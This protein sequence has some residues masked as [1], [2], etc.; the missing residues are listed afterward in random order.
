[1]YGCHYILGLFVWAIQSLNLFSGE[2]GY[3]HFFST[4]LF[5]PLS[6]VRPFWPSF[7]HQL[8]FTTGAW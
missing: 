7:P 2:E 6:S 3:I 8:A 4:S 1:M 5:Y